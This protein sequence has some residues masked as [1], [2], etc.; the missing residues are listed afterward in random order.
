MRNRKIKFEVV[1]YR[2]TTA[3]TCSYCGKKNKRT[4]TFYQT[5]NPFN[6]NSDGTVKTKK[7]IQDDLVLSASNWI[8]KYCIQC[9]MKHELEEN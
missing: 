3:I 4:K 8:P 5:I 9:E 2:K 1:K 7:D 6:K